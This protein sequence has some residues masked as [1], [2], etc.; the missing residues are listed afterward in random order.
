MGFSKALLPWN[1]Q[2]LLCAHLSLYRSLNLNVR[3]ITGAHRKQLLPLLLPYSVDEIH[4][5]NWGK[6]EQL[7]SLSLGIKD[8]N[9]EDLVVITPVDTAVPSHGCIRALIAARPPAVL[10]HRGLNGHP[11]LCRVK[12]LQNKL[13]QPLYKSLVHATQVE[14]TPSV[15]W[16]FNTPQSWMESIGTRATPV[17]HPP[18]NK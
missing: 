3:V 2:P 17:Y 9:P 18:K 1:N 12:W 11:I 5:P 8:L 10:S 15:L 6:E 13:H 4:S 16:N 7:D 14:S